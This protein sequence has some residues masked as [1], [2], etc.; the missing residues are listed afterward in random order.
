MMSCDN[1]VSADDP[2]GSGSTKKLRRGRFRIGM[3]E[4]FLLV[5]CSAVVLWAVRRVSDH[6][7]PV[8]VAARQLQYDLGGDRQAALETLTQASGS[9]IDVALPLLIKLQAGAGPEERAK[10]LSGMTALLIERL[11]PLNRGPASPNLPDPETVARQAR[12][13]VDVLLSALKSPDDATR[14][15]VAQSLRMLLRRETTLAVIV[16]GKGQAELVQTDPL[17]S[18]LEAALG[19]SVVSVR[20]DAAEALTNLGL[21]LARGPSPALRRALQDPAPL[22]RN[23]AAVAVSRLDKGIDP[24]LPDL[25]RIMTENRAEQNEPANSVRSR[26]VGAI[27]QGEFRPTVDSIPLLR[28]KLSSPHSEIRCAA[29]TLL[30]RIGLDAEEAVPDLIAALKRSLDP[31]DHRLVFD[32]WERREIGK[33]I[34][35]I[36][37]QG[38]V[39]RQEL[40]PTL[41]HALDLRVSYARWNAIEVLQTLGPMAEPAVPALIRAMENPGEDGALPNMAATALVQI[42]KGTPSAAR[43]RAALEQAFENHLIRRNLATDLADHAP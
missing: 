2:S 19:D 36:D 29:A 15:A 40:V 8:R 3:R 26:C 7:N 1:T 13:V 21:A 14:A 43:A 37:P 10:C 39:I 22:V 16:P 11:A 20:A 33:A 27:L 38:P 35:V 12:S 23:V 17:W 24:C 4:V 32:P 28:T 25:F 18:G 30:G 41:V 42:A 34:F 9:E 31:D 5:A 6:L